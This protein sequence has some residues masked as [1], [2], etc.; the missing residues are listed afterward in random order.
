MSKKQRKS[1]VKNG[2]L[3]TAQSLQ[4][5]SN[6]LAYLVVNTGNLKGKKQQDLVPILSDLGFNKK[7]IATVL[8]ATPE[9]VSE[10]LAERKAASKKAKKKSNGH[11]DEENQPE[12]MEQTG[13]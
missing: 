9:A 2:N 10:R 8:Q 1:S 4:Q 13:S 6:S 12:M 5:I 11:V 3:V 7:V